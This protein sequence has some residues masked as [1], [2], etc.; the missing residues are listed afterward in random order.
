MVDKKVK[1][2]IALRPFVRTVIEN[3]RST[4]RPIPSVS[5]A[6][7]ALIMLGIKAVVEPYQPK[8]QRV[9]EVKKEM[10]PELKKE[11]VF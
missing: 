9:K 11:Q 8:K 10:V 6:V 2:S 1:T 3:Y 4:K 7:E 5:E